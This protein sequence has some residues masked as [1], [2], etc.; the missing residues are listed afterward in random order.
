MKYTQQEIDDLIDKW[1]DDETEFVSLRE[2]LGMTEKEY[3]DF[4][5]LRED[6]AKE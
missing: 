5:T 4:V 3:E 6:N 2:Y 1:H